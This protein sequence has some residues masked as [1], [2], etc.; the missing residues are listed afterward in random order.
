[1]LLNPASPDVWFGQSISAMAL[2]LDTQAEAA[3]KQTLQLQPGPDWYRRRAYAALRYGIDATAAAD[4]RRCLELGGLESSS[5]PYTAFVAAIAYWRL[6]RQD[7]ATRILDEV[8]PVT[9]SKSSTETVLDFLQG[10]YPQRSAGRCWLL[11]VPITQSADYSMT[12]FSMAWV[13]EA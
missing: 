10:A 3:M 4:V 6:G 1:M 12:R 13:S 8:R 9:P 2:G 11:K 7:E 5:S